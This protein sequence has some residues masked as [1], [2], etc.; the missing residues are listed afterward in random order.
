MPR[1]RFALLLLL[2]PL[3]A[4][5]C[6]PN[7][8]PPPEPDRC[9]SA[10]PATATIVDLAISSGDSFVPLADGDPTLLERGGQGSN[11]MVLRVGWQ[12]AE[13]LA[14]AHVLLEVLRASD[15]AT[16]ESLDADLDSSVIDPWQ[17]TSRLYFIADDFPDEVIVRATVYDVTFE[18]RVR[19]G[20]FGEIDAGPR[21]SGPGVDSGP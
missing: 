13:P 21:D 14:C 9:E 6:G 7:P 10:A 3:C 2:T 5:I 8:P 11:M 1:Y 19:V 20:G 15:G 18:R 17:A 16:L 4:C 12:S